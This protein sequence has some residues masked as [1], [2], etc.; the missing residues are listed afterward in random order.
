MTYHVGVTAPSG[1]SAGKQA[2]LALLMLALLGAAVAGA[3]VLQYSAGRQGR[4]GADI[5][6]R[7]RANGLG[8]YWHDE[9]RIRW[10]LIQS[11]PVVSGWMVA[12]RQQPGEGVYEG[13]TVGFPNSA[14]SSAEH[15]TENWRLN[16]DATRGQY[17]GT[18]QA[19]PIITRLTIIALEPGQV[20]VR[21]GPRQPEARSAAPDN[22]IPE[23]ALPLVIRQVVAEK[24]DAQFK[25]VFDESPAAGQEVQFTTVRIRYAG[26]G[27]KTRGQPTYLARMS[28]R[29]WGKQVI[30]YQLD[31]AGQILS[32][33]YGGGSTY[34]AVSQQAL[35]GRFPDAL[36]RLQSVTGQPVP[37]SLGGIWRRLLGAP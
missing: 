6:R 21:Q 11:G 13:Y 37:S 24:A 36:A 15:F 27:E 30:T 4:A 17:E 25:M 8:H 26:E 28:H 22:Y 35:L 7:V 33:R 10:Y 16:A 3:W 18:S 19:G 29:E 2:M 9:E 32:I 5:L 23:G 14:H 31:Q 20:T 34:R 12:V 1:Q